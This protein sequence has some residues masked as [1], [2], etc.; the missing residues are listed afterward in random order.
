LLIAPRVLVVVVLITSIRRKLY[1]QFPMFFTYIASELVQ[2]AVILPMLLSRSTMRSGYATAYLVALALSTALRFGVIHEIF[3]HMFRNYA[4]LDRFGKPLFRWLTVGLLLAGLAIAVYA[5][6]SE[7]SRMVF[8]VLD[9]TAS[10]LQCGLLIGLFLFSGYLGLS[11]RSQLFGIALGVGV[12]AST[13]LAIFAIRSQTGSTYN[14]YLNYISMAAYH[15]SVLIWMFYLLAPERISHY[16]LKTVPEND[17]ET[18][19][20][21][22]QR[23]LGQ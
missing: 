20:Q 18:W 8:A 5:R 2:A 11:W 19:N 6:G 3:T 4:S 1:R 13:D 16:S 7:P 9:R 23:L 22:L 15:C 10:M 12:F 17:L 21:E 14:L